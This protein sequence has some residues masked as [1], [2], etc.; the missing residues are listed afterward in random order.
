MGRWTRRVFGLA[1]LL[2]PACVQAKDPPILTDKDGLIIHRGHCHFDD[3]GVITDQDT[4]DWV[5]G[6]DT[7]AREG[8]YWFGRFLRD[9]TPGMPKWPHDR[10]QTFE[11]VLNKL[12]PHHDGVIYRHPSL[13]GYNN[14]YDHEHG[15]SRDQLVPLIAAMGLA[16]NQQARILRIWNALPEDRVGKHSFQNNWEKITGGPGENCEDIQ[17]QACPLSTQCSFNVPLPSC[18]TPLVHLNCE[19]MVDTRSCPHIDPTCLMPAP[20]PGGIH[21]PVHLPPVPDPTC[22]PKVAAEAACIAARV[23]ANRVWEPKRAACFTAQTAAIQANVTNDAVCRTNN[24]AIGEQVSKMTALCKAVQLGNPCVAYKEARRQLCLSFN[25]DKTDLF[26]PEYVN[27]ILRA[28]GRNP[29]LPAPDLIVPG[30]ILSVTQIA[31]Q[32]GE[33]NM[34]AA[35]ELRLPAAD[36]DRDDSGPDLNVIIELLLA[37]VRS[38]T[39]EAITA[40]HDLATKRRLS[41]GSFLRSYYAE[42]GFPI[43]DARERPPDEDVHVMDL[44]MAQGWKPDASPLVGGVNWYHRAST[45]GNPALATLYAPLIDHYLK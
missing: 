33:A 40:A 21:L 38:R 4:C 11:Q 1:M 42:H 5:D 8:W 9:Q 19:G 34:L 26:G 18:S 44:G 23:A 10:R 13:P 31:G 17:K 3:K 30:S 39:P 20:V 12:E 43:P 35:S 45:G 32:T 28:L 27:L 7:A 16:G 25:W 29:L 36:K 24:T 6:G 15:T 2:A 41:H 22:P 37:Q 14:P